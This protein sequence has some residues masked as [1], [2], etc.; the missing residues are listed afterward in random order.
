M[1]GVFSDNVKIK[2]GEL[3]QIMLKENEGVVSDNV[4]RKWGELFQMMLQE[5][6]GSC[7]R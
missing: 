1:R 3:F 6:E 7:F 2:W 5:N 4:K